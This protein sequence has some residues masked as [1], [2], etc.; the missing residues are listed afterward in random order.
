MPADDRRM[1]IGGELERRRLQ[2]RALRLERMIALLRGRAAAVDASDVERSGLRRALGEFRA[3]LDA[4]R[5]KLDDD[6]DARHERGGVRVR[7]RGDGPAMSPG[8]GG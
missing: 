1:T 7:P 4:I 2:V 5:A 6:D 3:E 8:T